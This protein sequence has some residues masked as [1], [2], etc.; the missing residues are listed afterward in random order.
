MKL[1]LAVLI[2]VAGLSSVLAQTSGPA[3]EN[4]LIEKVNA[5]LVARNWV[6]A[7]RVL[8]QLIVAAPSRWEYQKGLAEAQGNQ[9]R[10][11]EALA[12]YDR[13]IALAEKDAN[14][15]TAKPALAAMWLAKGNVLLKLKNNAAAVAAY[16]KSAALSATPAV[17]YFNLC[18]TFYNMG[19]TKDALAACDKA[20][21]ADPSK[22]DAYFIKGSVLFADATVDAKG[23]MVFPPTAIASL[24]KY[25]ELAPTGGHAADVKEMLAAAG[26]STR[27]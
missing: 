5:A 11:Q 16:Q 13:A 7:E 17:A 19:Q 10:Y 6:E 24:K 18:A 23:K 12:S 25:L 1:I 3:A 14:T 26:D 9:A 4:A 22:A 2:V 27:R 21:A 20:I 8:K 15:A